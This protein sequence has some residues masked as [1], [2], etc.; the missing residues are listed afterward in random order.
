[1]ININQLFLYL[2]IIPFLGAVIIFFI[3]NDLFI[4]KLSLFIFF[5]TFQLSLFFWIFFDNSVYQFQFLNSINWIPSE[6]FYYT[7]GIDGISLFFIILTT[8]LIPICVLAS[9]DSIKKNFKEFVICFLILESILILSFSVLDILLF[10]IFFESILIPMFLII[11][12]WGSRERKIRAAYYFFLYTL[13]GSLFMLLGILLIYFETGTTDLQTL[14]FIKFSEKRQLLLWLAFFASFSVKVPMIPFHIWLPEAHV[15][16]PTA[17]SLVLAGILLKLGTYGFLRF[18]LNLFPW[19]TIY[20]TPLVFTM[21]VIG[22]VYGS[23]TTLRQ[24]DLKKIIAYSS[25]AHMNFVVLGIFALNLQG[26]EGSILLMLSHGIVSPALFLAIGVLYDRYK[27][28][29]LNYYSGL[30]QV[31]PL[32]AIFFGFFTL[33]N[34]SLPTTSSF[35]GEFLVLLG[36]FRYN[37]IAAFIATLGIILGASYSLWLYNRVIFGNI[38]VYYLSYFYDLNRRETFLFIPL[39]L[40]SLWMGIYPTPFLNCMHSSCG[41]LL[42]IYLI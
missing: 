24:I 30:V 40:I 23:L 33:A 14:S 21:G 15:E 1:M 35:V 41:Y 26:I 27:S 8:F 3:N 7:V 16:S 38:K 36:A 29:I 11:G 9:W 22:I 42:S 20:F 13:V 4:K 37:T 17:G 28:R 34:I 6:N 25:V 32:F 10:Y 39:V 2:P 31:M 18:S 5:V 12:I 19:A